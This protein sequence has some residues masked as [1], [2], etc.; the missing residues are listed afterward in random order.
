MAI[1]R[2]RHRGNLTPWSAL[3]DLDTELDRF[4]GNMAPDSRRAQAPWAPAVDFTE[5]DEAFTIEADLPG[6]KKDDVE[7][8][9]EEDTLTIRGERK[10]ERK[11]GENKRRHYERRTGKFERTFHIRDGFDADKIQAKF[12]DG[13]LRVVLPKKEE[14]KPRKIEVK[15][16]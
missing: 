6:L 4:F 15:L 7:V 3:R 1:T 5:T 2:W 8:V 13:V 12:E 14:A 9:A 10:M 16:N 11:A